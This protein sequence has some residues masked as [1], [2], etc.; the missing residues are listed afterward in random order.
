MTM[1]VLDKAFKI[2]SA[3]GAGA[4]RIVVLGAAEGECVLPAGANALG[5]LGATTH[6]A[7]QH[8]HVSVRRLG[9]ASAIAADAIAL[10]SPICVADNTGRIKAAAKASAVSGVVGSN[11]AIRWTALRPGIVGNNIIVDIVVSGNN[12]PFSIS[13]SGNIITINAATDGSGN[14][15][16][17]AAQARAA[18][19]EHTVASKIISSA[20][21]GASDGSGIIADE[22]AALSGGEHGEGVFG[23]AEQAASA[24]GDIINI[25]LTP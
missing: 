22:T 19:S 2:T 7:A 17:T 15:V 23:F 1:S 4:N 13:V 16:T 9:V 8:H 10:G 25:F 6:S 5:V 14:A 18:I 21:E 20:N 24:A 3:G 12:T 11:N